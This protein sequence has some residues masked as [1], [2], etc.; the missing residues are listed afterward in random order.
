[1]IQVHCRACGRPLRLS[2]DDPDFV[3]RCLGC[4]QPFRLGDLLSSQG[5]ST[6]NGPTA[7]KEEL[8]IAVPAVIKASEITPCSGPT[9]RSLPPMVVQSAPSYRVLGW[10]IFAGGLLFLLLSLGFALGLGI[11][12]ATRSPTTNVPS[13]SVQVVEQPDNAR[14]PSP[15]KF[16][17]LLAY[18][19]FD[20]GKGEQAKDA[21]G[22]G[23]LAM[24][25]RA[26]W[27]DGIRGKAL[28]LDGEG[29]YLDYS[30]A[31][32]LNFGAGAPFTIAFWERTR[33][34]QAT[35]LSQRHNRDGGA[36]I[37][38]VIKNGR[39]QVQV[40]QDGNDL[41]RP[42]SLDGPFINDD[43][44]HHLALTRVDQRIELF[45]DGIAHGQN[46]GGLAGGAIT[47]NLRALGAER[48]WIE[49]NTPIFGNPHFEGDLDEFCIFERVLKA[50]EIKSLAEH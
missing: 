45:L 2:D 5:T 26:R 41:F 9:L 25:V 39:V 8:P 34:D 22:N 27:T 17:G 24:L 12:L 28:H 46:S 29:S 48:Y 32:R 44:W 15:R 42:V 13:E 21:S 30:D 35:L 31:P 3:G 50:E 18:W 7:R 6:A 20:E 4:G 36:V 43:R 19:S 10:C 1:M 37:D 11:F 23:Q 49:R 40:R 14:T 16:P 38:M 47:T 33:R